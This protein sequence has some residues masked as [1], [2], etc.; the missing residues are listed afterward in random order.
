MCANDGYPHPNDCTKCICPWGFGGQ[1]CED[2]QKA[3]GELVSEDCGE[4]IK[5][6][7][8]MQFIY[9]ILLI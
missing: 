7:S 9:I 8:L 6:I 3:S 5:V 2:L 1:F 4:T